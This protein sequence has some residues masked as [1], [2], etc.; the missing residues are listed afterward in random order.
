MPLVLA[1]P[2]PDLAPPMAGGR[3]SRLCARWERILAPRLSPGQIT[4]CRRFYNEGEALKARA[5]RLLARLLALR[6]LPRGCSLDMDELSRPRVDCAPGWHVAFSHSGRAAFC[7]VLAPGDTGQLPQGHSALDAEA[8]GNL[9]PT[10]RGFAAPAPTPRAGL[11]RWLL[12]E[13]LFKA[14]GASPE[15][16]K[17][18]ACAAHGAPGRTAGCSRMAGAPFSWRFLPA[19]GH[20]LCVA[21]PGGEPF[22]VGLRWLPWQSFL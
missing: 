6:V 13:A 17:I 3:L 22:S 15:L 10:D 2:L 11:R 19:P 4:H 5:S 7:L 12:A 21:F 9:P 16:W 14:L 20:A 1:A 18:A 8:V